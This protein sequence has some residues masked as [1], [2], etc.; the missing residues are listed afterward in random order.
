MR[1][2]GLFVCVCVNPVYVSVK[3]AFGV[4]STNWSARRSTIGHFVPLAVGGSHVAIALGHIDVGARVIC[5]ADRF[6]LARFGRVVDVVL[7]REEGNRLLV[8]RLHATFAI[9]FRR[10]RT[11]DWTFV[12]SF[13][14]ATGSICALTCGFYSSPLPHKAIEL[15]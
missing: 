14:P 12:E 10:E 5:T 13:I 11:T 4:A 9:P 7:E 6:A 3:C 1:E 15:F 8:H 2:E